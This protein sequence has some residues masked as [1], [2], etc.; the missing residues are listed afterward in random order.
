MRERFIYDIE[1]NGLLDTMDRIHCLVLY[2]MDTKEL[3]SYRNDGHP[4]NYERLLEGVRLLNNAKKRIGHNIIKFDEMALHML[5]PWF[6]PNVPGVTVDTLTLTRLIKPNVA[7]SDRLYVKRGTLDGRLIGSHSLEAWGQRLGEWKGDFAKVRQKEIMEAQPTISKEE[8]A[9]L[10]WANW[11]QEMQ[12]YCD[13]DVLT[14]LAIYRWCQRKGYSKQAVSDELDM[15]YLCAKIEQNGFPFDERNAGNLY[16]RLAG[17]R[18]QLEDKLRETFGSWVEPVGGTYVPKS[19]NRTQG[20]WGVTTWRFLDDETELGPEDFTKGGLPNA[21]AKRRGVRR[22]F[23]GYPLTKIKIVDFN[24]TSRFHIAKRLTALYGWE[25]TEFTPDGQPKVDEDIMSKLPYDCAPLLTE[26]FTVIKRIGQL[27]EG[28]QAWLKLVRNGRIHG[29]YNTVGAVTRRMTHS[30][31]NIAQVPGV[32]ADFGAECR[33]LFGPGAGWIQVG[34]DASGLELRMLAHFMARWDEGAYGEVILNGDIHTHNQ[35]LAGLPERGMAKTL[36]YA[37]LYGGGDGKLG[38]IVG[39]S[40]A[41]GKKLRAKF[42]EGLPALAKL[43][44]AVKAKAKAHK[45][46]NALDGGLLHV[47]SEHSALNTLLQSAGALVCKKWTVLMERILIEQGFK[48][49]WDGD[50]VFMANI[51]DENQ[52]ACRTSEIADAVEA[53]SVA[54]MNQVREYYGIRIRLDVESMRGSNWKECH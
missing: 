19:A 9:R 37:F 21:A 51:H 39:G 44:K 53:A 41:D 15:A 33:E 30:N 11:S 34:T 25:P 22:E 20:Y 4:D 40:A 29:S 47:R 46:L 27:A 50:F 1:T 38:E 54:A 6:T 2:D 14:N 8:A 49:G 48:H 5:F 10:V 13:Q 18:A 42:L 12:D 26:Y 23:D 17:R 35:T 36:I 45:H 28:K 24:P 52:I 43:V 32:G 16:A 7:D 3:L 31:P